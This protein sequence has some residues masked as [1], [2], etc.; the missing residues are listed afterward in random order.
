[1]GLKQWYKM[2]EKRHII[3]LNE[4]SLGV[5][6]LMILSNIPIRKIRIFV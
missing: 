3:S 2:I 5:I 6:I 4:A 1:M